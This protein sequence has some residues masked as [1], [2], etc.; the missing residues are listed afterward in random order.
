[1][2]PHIFVVVLILLVSVEAGLIVWQQKKA[3]D[4]KFENIGL[5]IQVDNLKDGCRK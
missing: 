5:R 1:M 3:A 2:K 4:L